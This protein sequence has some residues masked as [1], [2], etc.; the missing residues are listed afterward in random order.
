MT[1]QVENRLQAFVKLGIIFA[2]S[3]SV[4]RTLDELESEIDKLTKFR[5]QPLGLKEDEFRKAARDMLRTGKYKPTGRSKPASEYLIR[6]AAE[7]TFP[8]INTVVDINNYISLKYLIPIS[9]WDLDKVKADSWLFRT[10]NEDESFVFNPAGQTIELH[11][12]VTG[13]SVYKSMETPV[14]TPVKDSQLTKTD[15]DTRNIGVAI[16]Y[17]AHWKNEP[18]L[19]QITEEF[20]GFLDKISEQVTILYR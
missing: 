17:P 6:S 15:N 7:N 10:G 14:V 5:N 9:L 19:S 13:F 20:A 11:D 1:N 3:V 8:R 4:T 2:S 18:E 12:L 16:Y